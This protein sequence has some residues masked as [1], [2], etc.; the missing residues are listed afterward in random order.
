MGINAHRAFYNSGV[1]DH[2]LKGLTVP[3]H[4]EQTLREARD[5]I[6]DAIRR[7]F[8]DWT[9]GLRR[10]QLLE[11]AALATV[12]AYDA[13]PTLRPKFRGQGSYSYRTL[14]RPTQHE[15][16]IDIDDGVFLPISFLSQNGTT[17]PALVSSAYFEAVE[18]ILRPLCNR[19]G[20]KLKRKDT[21]V[22]VELDDQAHID[23]ALYA[24]PDDQFEL[25]IEKAMV[26]R[27][28]FSLNDEAEAVAFAEQVYRELPDDQIMLAHR[29]EGWKQS[30]PRKLEDWFNEAVREHGYQLRRMCR[31]LKGWRDYQ[32][33]HCR[34][35][36]IALMA[37]VV[38]T[39][40]EAVASPPEDR[41]DKALLRIAER[42]PYMLNGPIA[43]PVVPG[44]FLDDGWSAECRRE[45]VSRAGAL[46]G[47]LGRALARNDTRQAIRDLMETF[48]IFMPNDSGVLSLDG[49]PSILTTGLLSSFGDTPEAQGA[50][51][52]G[53]DDRYG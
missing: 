52:K 17:H 25:L 31:Y 33:T 36:S 18:A 32:W 48:G 40:D 15:Q 21:C 47:E 20:W 16:Q 12:Y 9:H 49:S 2:Y 30:D 10:E 27:R 1:G 22:R 6:R 43:N 19:K 50:V 42:L 35:S 46:A 34:L 11:A 14:N 37:C 28:E 7:G 44:Q 29:T 8:R 51:Q 41:D 23:L 45:F 38:A 5:D 13:E 39:Y 24:I 26:A 4:D 3:E 53:G